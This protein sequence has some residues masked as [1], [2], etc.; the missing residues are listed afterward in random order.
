MT[1][2]IT[3]RLDERSYKMFKQAAEGEHRTISNF[4][5]YAA[6]RQLTADETVSDAE[7]R[8]ITHDAAL[9]KRLSAGLE[10]VK[11]GRYTVVS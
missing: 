10:D 11:K 5:E 6:L 7:M 4:I 2:T 1:K 8:E 9:M 3:L